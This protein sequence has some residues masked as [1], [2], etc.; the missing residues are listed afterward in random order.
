SHQSMEQLV[1]AALLNTVDRARKCVELSSPKDGEGLVREAIQCATR[2][3]RTRLLQLN[4]DLE[5]LIREAA[6]AGDKNLEYQLRQK[7]SDVR[8]LL[9]TL[10]TS[11]HL[12]G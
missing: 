6:D 3:K 4:T 5:N 11:S 1:P 2:L 8:S 10:Y 7:V 12:H 9:Q